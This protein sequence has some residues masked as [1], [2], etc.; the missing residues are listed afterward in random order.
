MAHATID[1]AHGSFTQSLMRGHLLFFTCKV[2]GQIFSFR[3]TF[4]STAASNNLRFVFYCIFCMGTTNQH[5]AIKLS[6]SENTTQVKCKAWII[7]RV[8]AYRKG[9][10]YM[11]FTYYSF[12][13]G[14]YSQ[15]GKAL[16]CIQPNLPFGQF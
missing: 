14:Y 6:Q 2:C 13:C 3:S 15:E 1:G 8:V 12:Q 7:G 16:N 4:S 9:G 5:C 10:Y 11:N